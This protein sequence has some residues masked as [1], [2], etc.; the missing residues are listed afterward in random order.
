MK[1]NP[2]VVA[3]GLVHLD[4]E[5]VEQLHR[6]RARNRADHLARPVRRTASRRAQERRR[7]GGG[8]GGGGGGG[9]RGKVRRA[10]TNRGS[11][12]AE[13]ASPRRPA[14][15][16]GSVLVPKTV[17][18]RVCPRDDDDDDDDGMC[19]RVRPTTRDDRDGDDDGRP[20]GARAD[21]PA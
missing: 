17:H 10:A 7:R 11:A 19:W 9:A 12:R 3:L 14:V 2:L 6:Q 8:G 18:S 21:R 13:V 15:S 1:A 20:R 4:P 16:R 5:L